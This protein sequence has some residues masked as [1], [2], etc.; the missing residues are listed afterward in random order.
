MRCIAQFQ[1]PGQNLAYTWTSGPLQVTP[2]L[3][4]DLTR[5]QWFDKE[6]VLGEHHG[7]M[8]LITEFKPNNTV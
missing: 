6:Q 2:E 1:L 4:A 3:I 7:W 5:R 8:K